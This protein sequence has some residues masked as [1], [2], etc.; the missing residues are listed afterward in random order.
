MP[1]YYIPYDISGA[2]KIEAKTKEKAIESFWNMNKTN[3]KTLISNLGWAGPYL[4]GDAIRVYD[5]HIEE[6][7][8]DA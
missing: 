3:D 7:E 5:E 1:R 8:E 6:L 2:M 4:D